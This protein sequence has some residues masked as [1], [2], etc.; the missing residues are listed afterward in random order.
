MEWGGQMSNQSLEE[1]RNNKEMGRLSNGMEWNNHLVWEV[2][3]FLE[4]V[5]QLS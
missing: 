3:D 4:E 1:G 2:Q 5:T